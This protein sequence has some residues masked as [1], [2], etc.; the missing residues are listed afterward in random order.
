MTFSYNSITFL[1]DPLLRDDIYDCQLWKYFVGVTE[2][3]SLNWS[4][5]INFR[6][7]T[8]TFIQY[9]WLLFFWSTFWIRITKTTK[10]TKKGDNKS[11]IHSKRESENI[12]LFH[13]KRKIW[14]SLIIFLLIFSLLQNT[15]TDTQTKQIERRHD[16]TATSSLNCFVTYHFCHSFGEYWITFSQ[17]LFQ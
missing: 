14:S 7:T 10:T 1:W 16:T 12:Y 2:I 9:S 15:P 4:E 17:P 13:F 5:I 3:F 8:H 11:V 6:L